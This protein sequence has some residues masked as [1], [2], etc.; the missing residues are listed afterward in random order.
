[1]NDYRSRI[2]EIISVIPQYYTVGYQ[3]NLD[4]VMQQTNALIEITGAIYIDMIQS[5]DIVHL[6]YPQIDAIVLASDIKDL[7]SAV[8]VRDCLQFADLLMYVIEPSLNVYLDVQQRHFQNKEN[9]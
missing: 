6:A 3:G 2:S 8:E 1:M 7:I 5:I 9:H 4:S